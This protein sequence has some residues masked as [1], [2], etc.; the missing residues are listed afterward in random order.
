MLLKTRLS[1]L[2]YLFWWSIILA[3]VSVFYHTVL[4]SNMFHF[5]PEARTYIDNIYKMTFGMIVTAMV[6]SAVNIVFREI[7]YSFGADHLIIRKFLPTLRF[8]TLLLIWI[9]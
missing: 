3:F 4:S 9:V 7:K 6:A 2:W 1:H 5:T 8:T